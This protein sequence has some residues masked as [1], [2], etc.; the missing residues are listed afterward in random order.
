MSC[1][2]MEQFFKKKYTQTVAEHF[3]LKSSYEELG[4]IFFQTDVIKQ[5][6]S[7]GN[8]VPPDRYEGTC[9]SQGID[10]K[11]VST[12]LA[13]ANNRCADV[14]F[15]HFICIGHPEIFFE[16][17]IHTPPSKFTYNSLRIIS[18]YWKNSSQL[19]SNLLIHLLDK[20]KTRD[21]KD[22]EKTRND[23]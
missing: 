20:E 21:G 22:K 14:V 13:K 16:L 2:P 10:F 11:G 23:C 8:H 3:R 15:R 6:F 12:S 7:E 18:K 19:L 9:R 17:W 1:Q 5:R 4:L